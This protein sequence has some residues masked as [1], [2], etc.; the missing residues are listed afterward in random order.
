MNGNSAVKDACL[1]LSVDSLSLCYTLHECIIVV[2]FIY[3][4]HTTKVNNI[5]HCLKIPLDELAEKQ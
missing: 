5:L 1:V 2:P 3:V 4:Y